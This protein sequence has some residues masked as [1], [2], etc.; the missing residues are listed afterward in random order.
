[1]IEKYLVCLKF[2]PVK[3]SS[4]LL[5]ISAVAFTSS[6]SAQCSPG[7]GSLYTFKVGNIKYE[8]VKDGMSWMEAAA[9]AVYRGGH[10]AE[11][12]SRA[13]QDSLYAHAGRASIITSNTIAP[14]G[15]GAAYLWLGGNDKATEGKWIW[16]GK[17]S[18]TGVQFWQGTQGGSAVN[19]S[20]TNWG[21]EPDDFNSD[22]DALGLAL[23][24]WPLGTSGQWNDVDEDNLLYFIVEY[25]PD[26]IT[27]TNRD[28][29]QA[30]YRVYPN[31]AKN[32]IVVSAE[33][34]HQSITCF[35]TNLQGVVISITRLN[36]SGEIPL[37]PTLPTGH[38]ILQFFG[39]NGEVLFREKLVIGEW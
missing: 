3:N 37:S 25:A 23:T 20:F 6:A 14:D 31:P 1:M 38:Y 5:L 24:N 22:Q 17:N 10:L 30:H 13:E 4:I 9:C 18:G 28:L 2:K 35:L 21:N 26:T 12:N 19:G 11:V 16:D 33:Q 32:K 27:S 36:G 29:N 39:T 34:E 7:A 15:G 8:I